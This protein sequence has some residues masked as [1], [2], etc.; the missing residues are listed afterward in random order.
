DELRASHIQLL[1]DD[2]EPEKIDPTLI[3]KSTRDN[4]L[5]SSPLRVGDVLYFNILKDTNEIQIDHRSDH[6]VGLFILEGVRQIG[7]AMSHVLADIP[8]DTRMSLQEFSL[9]FYNYIEMD[10]PIVAR[11]VGTLSLNQDLRQ[12]QTAFID[13]RQNG[14]T[15]LAGFS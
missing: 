1:P 3:R 14:V 6:Y 12:D 9:Y 4:C 10:Y 2:P 15:C 13:V 8:R 7:M 11:A 5:L